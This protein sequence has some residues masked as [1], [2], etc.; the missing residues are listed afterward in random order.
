MLPVLPKLTE[1]RFHKQVVRLAELMGW[2]VWHD[3]ATNAPRA[4]AACDTPIP[5]IRNP[6]GM[7]DL[8]LIRRPRVVWAELKSERGTLTD[9]QYTALVE[10]R[11][12][13]QEAHVWRPSDI[14]K[15]TRILR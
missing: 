1:R 11:A 4:C 9:A 8:I 15:I 6:A 10:L 7:L 2:R 5:V 14:E 3:T 13:G 12:S